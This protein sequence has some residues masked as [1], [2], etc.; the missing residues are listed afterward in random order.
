MLNCLGFI[1][2]IL[3]LGN[4]VI[5]LGDFNFSC[6]IGHP[7]FDRASNIFS[8]FN[9]LHCDDLYSGDPSGQF[10][11]V[12]ISLNRRSLIDHVFSSYS[13]KQLIYDIQLIDSGINFSDHKPLVSTINLP[14][15]ILSRRVPRGGDMGECPPR[16]DF[17]T[18]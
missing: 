6:V 12:N 4:E 11:Y 7:G 9:V 16:Q 5:I 18:F 3:A 13:I 17:Q 14:I 10:S 1:E 8:N 2:N 15:K